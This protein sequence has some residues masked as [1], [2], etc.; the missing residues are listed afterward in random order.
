ML[1]KIVTR[2]TY[3]SPALQAQCRTKILGSARFSSRP[4]GNPSG[5]PDWRERW[6]S[7]SRHNFHST[8][9]L[10]SAGPRVYLDENIRTEILENRKC[11]EPEHADAAGIEKQ[12]TRSARTL[13]EAVRAKVSQSTAASNGHK[14]N[15]QEI[16]EET[17]KQSFF[18][19]VH[20]IASASKVMIFC[21]RNTA[22]GKLTV[23]GPVSAAI[24]A[25][26]LYKCHKVAIIVSDEPNK[27]LI[28][29][30]LTQLDPKCGKFITYL[31][32]NQVNGTLLCTLSKQIVTRKPDVSLY[33]DV[34]GRNRNGEYL[35]AKGNPIA[36]SNVG[37]DQA[38]NVQN[39]LK[40][41]TIAI[42][43][44]INNAGFPKI[45][46]TASDS[47]DDALRAVLP[48]KHSLVVDNVITGTLSLMEL[49]STAWTDLK[50][51]ETRQLRTLM[52]TA[53]RKVEDKTF[54][55]PVL[56][57]MGKARPPWQEAVP[58]EMT[59]DHPAIRALDSIHKLIDASHVMWPAAFEKIKL[60]GP[61]MRHVV[62][63]DSSD[64][65]LIAT[66]DF[67]DYVRARSRFHIKVHA[68]ADHEK[69]PYGRFL[70]DELFHVVVNGMAFCALLKADAIVMLCNTACTVG[71]HSVKTTVDKWLSSI[72]L[73]YKV[74]IIDLVNTVAAA[75]VNEGGPEPVLLS[76]QATKESNA[77][78]RA[79]EAAAKREGKEAPLIT[80]VGCG[81][82]DKRPQDDWAT[83]VN[84]SVYRPE[85]ADHQTFLF[86]V[87][88][89]VHQIPL[90]ASSIWLCCTHFPILREFIQ[91]VL[92]E[93]LAAN[94]MLEDSIPII[95]PLPYQAEATI[96][97]LERT[98]P[99]N[100][101]EY[102]AL[103]DLSVSTT[104][105]H[106]IVGKSV[107]AHIKREKP[108]VFE[109]AFPH[110]PAAQEVA[111]PASPKN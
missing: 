59:D 29:T 79:I 53:A 31:P 41:E 5:F 12:Y 33:I 43:S 110:V 18:P 39:A 58:I 19:A 108:P 25:Y 8:A 99:A 52:D 46:T 85:H 23:E 63:F 20:K 27:R 68:V 104:G 4:G 10:F 57:K 93:R 62:L 64:G 40:M 106:E 82:R 6:P 28:Q 96:A 22:E 105:R 90:S 107:G 48:A 75:I 66:E 26:A 14:G 86:A 65:V 36:L 95:D 74:E 37:F 71:L 54:Q 11:Y 100:G 32:I 69:R 73:H 101:K 45:D 88:S 47:G 17:L 102:G 51:C 34:P 21:G 16:A 83:F 15:L 3:P 84:D 44:G 78:P 91:R 13:I 2:A 76:T 49:V 38:L 92:N 89:Y 67:L 109:V 42:C 70:P 111:P 97:F 1:R 30:L 103:R 7:I 72:G 98:K 56:R 94:G 35:D 60:D 81:D 77:Y 50:A 9:S 80:V 87:K 61:E 24:A 55:A